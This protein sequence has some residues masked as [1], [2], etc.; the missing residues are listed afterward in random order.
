LKQITI[1]WGAVSTTFRTDSATVADLHDEFSRSLGI[2][3]ECDVR[4]NGI[5]GSFDDELATGA[6]VEFVKRTGS[7]G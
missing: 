3:E 1:I 2:P 7:K 5:T 4:V 6:S